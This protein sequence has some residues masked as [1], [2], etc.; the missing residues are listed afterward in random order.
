VLKHAKN[1]NQARIRQLYKSIDC[2]QTNDRPFF[3][4]EEN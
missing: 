2:K 1:L 4:E 3:I